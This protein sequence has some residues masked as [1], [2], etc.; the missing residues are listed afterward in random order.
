M[1]IQSDPFLQLLFLT[2]ILVLIIITDKKKIAK[3]KNDIQDERDKRLIPFLNLSIDRDQISLRMINDGNTPAYDVVIDDAE[4]VI[5]VGFQKKFLFRF[6]PIGFIKPGE[7]SLLDIEIFENNQ[8]IPPAM[9]KHIS[10][11]ILSSSFTA[12]IHCKNISGVSFRTE[13]I[14]EGPACQINSVTLSE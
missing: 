1:N 2:I 7:S 3:L 4:T 11:V 8:P 6:R 12:F 14:K 13:L 9:R 5:D 10:G